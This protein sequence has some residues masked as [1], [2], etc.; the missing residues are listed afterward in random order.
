LCG[1]IRGKIEILLSSILVSSLLVVL[2][3]LYWVSLGPRTV[4]GR[5][6]KGGC[7]NGVQLF[8]A[9]A[10]LLFEE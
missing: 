5:K 2:S 6:E 4:E 9:F 8:W 10:S 7:E 3:I 1:A